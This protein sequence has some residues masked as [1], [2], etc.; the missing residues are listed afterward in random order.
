M[1]S[2]SILKRRSVRSYKNEPVS[3]FDL[4]TVIKAAQ[5]APTAMNNRSVEFLVVRK[6]DLKEQLFQA[7]GQNYLIE[8]P[9]LIVPLIDEHRSVLPKSDLAIASSFM[10]LQAAEL[11]LGTVWKDVRAELVPR[12][13]EILNLPEKYTLIN[14]IPLGYAKEI[15]PPHSDEEF[16]DHKIHYNTW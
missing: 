6:T 15:L 8:A 1:L 13:R 5:M 9:V 11:G 2:S 14:I 10:L 7:L 3:D 16:A 4:M 12:V